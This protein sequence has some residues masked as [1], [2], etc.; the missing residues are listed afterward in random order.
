MGF[1]TSAKMHMKMILL[2]RSDASERPEIKGQAP[3][4]LLTAQTEIYHP[5]F[6]ESELGYT[7]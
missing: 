3:S 6:Q 4:E 7:Y 5:K 1:M 2:V